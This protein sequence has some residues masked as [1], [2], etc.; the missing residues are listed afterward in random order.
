MNEIQSKAH[1]I[2]VGNEKGGTGKSTIAM[3]IAVKLLQEN[4]KV[5]VID[6]DGRQGSL[7]KYVANRRNFIA[8][9]HVSLPSPVHYI[10]EP[11][12]GETNTQE[13]KD[14]ISQLDFTCECNCG[15]N[16]SDNVEENEG[17]LGD[18]EN[19]VDGNN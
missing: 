1:V 4:F 17:I 16:G 18:L 9:H 7:S 15:C 3:H 5:V 14:L 11:V 8:K 10:F 2:V 19:Y 13:I 6:M 12:Q